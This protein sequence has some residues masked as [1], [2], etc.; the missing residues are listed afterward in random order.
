[1][2]RLFGL[3]GGEQPVSATFW[4]LEA[5][6]SLA[7]QSCRNPDGFGI[8]TFRDGVPEVD[9]R[10]VRAQDDELYA[11][12]A[13]D[14]VSRT[15][16]AHVRYASVGELS[17]ENTHPFEQD[18]R[19]LGHNGV[20][21]DLDHVEERLGEARELLRGTTDSERLFALITRGIRDHGGDVRAGIVEATR[22]LAAE[23]PL[24]SL[25]FVLATPDEL[26]ALRYPEANELLVLERDP[27]GT[28]R[29]RHLDES[30]PYGTIRVRTDEARARPVVVV[31]S[32]A[33]D[34]DPAW[35]AVEPGELVRVGADL[36]VERELILPDP[37]VHALALEDLSGRA[38]DSQRQ[39]RAESLPG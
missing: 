25:N 30:S 19:L 31:A 8:G 4:L 34:E 12:Q 16:I 38:A 11:T 22:W 37:P 33:M 35:R 5:P 20:L 6:G 3:H 9:K 29:C 1:M 39:E 10:P 13:R 7:A 15:F 36:R 28:R 14:E 26:W 21:G 27:G 2:C 23:V 18:G 32:E 17:P 24:F